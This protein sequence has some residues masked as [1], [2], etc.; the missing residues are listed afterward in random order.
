M[1]KCTVNG[2]E[3]LFHFWSNVAY[4]IGASGFC[5]SYPAG[6]MSYPVAVVELLPERTIA[7]V[8]AGSDQLIF[9]EP[10]PEET[11]IAKISALCSPP[12]GFFIPPVNPTA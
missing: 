7:E 4:P 11:L 1:R 9:L 2:K 12:L 3:A 8:R 6:Q 10:S 5:N